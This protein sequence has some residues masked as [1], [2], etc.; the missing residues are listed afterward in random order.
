MVPI[1]SA[2][3]MVLPGSFT[4]PAAKVTLCQAS[5][6][7]MDPD[8]E[9]QIAANKPNP[10][11]ALSDAVSGVTSCGVQ[12]FPKLAAIAS[13]FQKI[14]PSRIS[15]ASAITLAEVNRF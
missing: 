8:C 13:C 10:V 14:S 12:K 4:S 3:G 6:E 7:N 9:T 1:A 11:S 5:A 15:P 2:R